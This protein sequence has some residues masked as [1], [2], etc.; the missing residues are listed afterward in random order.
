MTVNYTDL[1]GNP[2]KSVSVDEFVVDRTVPVITVTFDNNSAQ[3]GKY[4]KDPRTA[5][6][7]IREH[8]FRESEV[9]KKRRGKYS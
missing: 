1:A 7:S 4:Y 2:A 3:N 9:S 8:N 5:T 6:I